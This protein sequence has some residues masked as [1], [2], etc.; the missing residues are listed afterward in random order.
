MGELT[1]EQALG[2]IADELCERSVGYNEDHSKGCPQRAIAQAWLA[3]VR[4]E[5]KVQALREAADE[6]N[7]SASRPLGPMVHIRD[8]G[9]RDGLMKCWSMLRARADRMEAGE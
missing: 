9:L 2:F 8:I 1:T 5:A 4:R 6:L 3:Q 7:K